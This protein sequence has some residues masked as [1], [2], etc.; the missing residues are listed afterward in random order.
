MY[1][2]AVFS[3]IGLGS[4][5]NRRIGQGG[6]Y[7]TP[8]ASRFDLNSL[9]QDGVIESTYGAVYKEII[10]LGPDKSRSQFS[11]AGGVNGNPFG[12]SYMDLLGDFVSGKLVQMRWGQA[13]KEVKHETLTLMPDSETQNQTEL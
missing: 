6:N 12:R 5:A 9:P 1:K 10:S 2:N 13:I 4:L 3:G 7:N 11:I 8:D